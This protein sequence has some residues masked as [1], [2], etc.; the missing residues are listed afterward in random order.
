MQECSILFSTWQC[1]CFCRKYYINIKYWILK[2]ILCLLVV[3]EFA[4]TV[5]AF[6]KTGTIQVND[7]DGWQ[8]ITCTNLLEYGSDSAT[9]DCIS[10]VK[11]SVS[12]NNGNTML[13]PD[14]N[15][16]KKTFNE[17]VDRVNSKILNSVDISESSSSVQIGLG[18]ILL[19]LI[20][21]RKSHNTS[22]A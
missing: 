10:T 5:Q 16:Q 4:C 3:F 20:K 7:G 19:I 17:G 12:G 2:Y 22:R 8:T 14:C 13:L 1:S 9:R 11:E 15:E 18:I 6:A 21:W